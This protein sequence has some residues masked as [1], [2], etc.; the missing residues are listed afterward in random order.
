MANLNFPKTTLAS[1]GLEKYTLEHATNV[2]LGQNY[3]NCDLR[4]NFLHVGLKLQIITSLMEGFQRASLF[5]QRQQSKVKVGYFV[6]RQPV[7]V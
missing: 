4:F 1:G 6:C 7:Q 2:G 5:I 3:H